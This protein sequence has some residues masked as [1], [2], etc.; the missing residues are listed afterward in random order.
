[1]SA[2]GFSLTTPCALAGCAG[3]SRRRELKAREY[4]IPATNALRRAPPVDGLLGRPIR[5]RKQSQSPRQRISNH[6]PC[7]NQAVGYQKGNEQQ[8]LPPTPRVVR[9]PRRLPLRRCRL[10]LPARCWLFQLPHSRYRPLLAMSFILF[11]L[12]PLIV[13]AHNQPPRGAPVP[14]PTHRPDEPH[15][16][17]P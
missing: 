16:V 6:R 13:P 5:Q 7:V 14:A 8:L 2:P 15:P 4:P 12:L 1:M 11:L 3:T 9:G 17:R 10:R